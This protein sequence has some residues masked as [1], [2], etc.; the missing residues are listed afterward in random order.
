MSALA[1]DPARRPDASSGAGDARE[2]SRRL[3]VAF[4]AYQE[5]FARITRRA[6]GRFEE[7]DWTG[8]QRDASDRLLLYRAHLEDTVAAEVRR[9]DKPA[10]ASPDPA[11][12]NGARAE[13]RRLTGNRPDCEI[14]RTFFNSVSRRVFGTV[15]VRPDAEFLGLDIDP[16]EA[17]G[18]LPAYRSYSAGSSWRDALG[19]VLADLPF[20]RSLADERRDAR[21]VAGV[22]RQALGGPDPGTE[23]EF[24]PFPFYRNKGAYLVGRVRRGSD[25]TPLVIALLHPEG[26]VV[27]DAALLSSDETSVVFGFSRS[28]FHADA[29]RPRAAVDFLSSIMPRKRV[30]E[31]YTALG[32]NRH[33]KTEFYRSLLQHLR[34]PGARFEPT[35]GAEGMVMSVFTLPS[36]NVVFKVIRDR[37]AAPKRT[38]RRHVEERYRMVFVRDRVGR[39]ADAQ[40]FEGVELDA[41][42]F[43]PEVLSELL[44]EAPSTV[45]QKGDRVVI[46]HL[47]TVRRM[48]PLDVYLRRAEPEAA[49]AAL[50]DYG[51]AIRDL[52][53]ANIFPGDMFFKNFGVTRHGRVIFYDYDEL[54]LLTRCRFRRIPEAPHPEMELAEE[55]WF[56]VAEGD[57]FPEEFA[58]FIPLPPG[59]REDF[60]AAHGD[61]FD[62]DFWLQMQDRQRAGE[63][64]DFFP[65]SPDRRL[66]P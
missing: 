35:E 36:L 10:A 28:Y 63:V 47:Y 30:D 3:L 1:P 31:L 56:A 40:E 62:V 15:G 5:E 27:A 8:A 18:G 22:L 58:R 32:Y 41:G 7:R 34:R 25:L 14:A 54:T 55:P 48:S 52:A 45:R 20:R 24:L 44:R 53:A 57:V 17:W 33:G 65:Y 4:D 26:G 19:G 29:P 60:L 61:L 11:V 6:P 2:L 16:P 66:G 13:Y 42:L 59:L 38:S 51:S 50:L 49:R 23:L 39:L 12:W 64:V 9:L 46:D 43:S 37:F 21:R